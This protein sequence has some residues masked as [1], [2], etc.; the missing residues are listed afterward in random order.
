[1]AQTLQLTI[2]DAQEAE[3][4]LQ[5]AEANVMQKKLGLP[6]LT[7]SQYFRREAQDRLDLQARQ[8][9]D[10][11]ELTRKEIRQRMTPEDLA[12]L[13]AL[14]AKYQVQGASR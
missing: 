5:T 2:N 6:D 3:L 13:E 1:M 8:R 4:G 10:L 9:A 12:A 11:R 7:P 14:Y